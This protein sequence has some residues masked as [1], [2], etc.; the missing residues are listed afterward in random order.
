MKKTDK[1]GSATK[2]RQPSYFK[3]F[4]PVLLW[5]LIGALLLA[6]HY[7]TKYFRQTTVIFHALID[8]K[9]PSVPYSITVNGR[10][11]VPGDHVI[12]GWRTIHIIGEAVQP[13]RKRLWVWYGT[14]DL[15]EV[16]LTRAKGRLEMTV[17]PGPAL[18]QIE[19]PSFQQAI[20][21]ESAQV[22]SLPT[23]KYHITADFETFK[24]EHDV[25]IRRNETAQVHIRP[26][27]GFVQ[28]TTEPADAD[29][30]LSNLTF[31][32][33]GK[34][35][36]LV[37]L[38]AGEYQVSVSRAD[39]SKVLTVTVTP[40]SSNQVAV[41]FD[42][43][44]VAFVTAPPG[45]AIYDGSKEISHTPTT[46]KEL[47]PGNYRFRLELPEHVPISVDLEIKGT[48]ALTIKRNLV[49]QSFVTAMEAARG[50]LS[51]SAPDYE[52]ALARVETALAAAPESLDA[53][54][55][56]TRIE[57][58]LTEERDRLAEQK[59]QR[60]LLAA[61]RQRQ[62]EAQAAERRRAAQQ[63]TRRRL[64]E[65]TFREATDNIKDSELF[66]LQYWPVESQVG[67]VAA[68]IRGML[69]RPGSGWKLDNETNVNEEVFL[70]RCSGTKTHLGT[71]VRSAVIVIGQTGSTET[72]IFAKFWDYMLGKINL[73]LTDGVTKEM[74]P[75]HPRS[76]PPD[77]TRTIG[78]IE[79]RRKSVPQDFKTRLLNE[80]K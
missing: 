8:G 19:G 59:R 37:L 74:I 50:E 77:Q 70:F 56:K 40:G 65:A 29:F 28:I 76:F 41:K 68:A 39:Y 7:H 48:E 38:P 78:L 71:A 32:F 42:Y 43:G 13:F 15:G 6:L 67:A 69:Q 57:A 66:E 80:L 16:N 22:P 54:E 18:L 31:S 33:E 27:A 14:N 25:Q 10:L 1:A 62:V 36:R 45:A 47:K 9:L 3:I 46:I 20:R 73:S 12:P 23:G 51:R 55:L 30:K 52:F 24:E 17:A 26:A 44:E 75:V 61:H 34:T 5:L 49:K 63:E 60:E 11:Y 21:T 53:R 72:Q 35:P 58:A 64:P 2:V 4:G 79:Q